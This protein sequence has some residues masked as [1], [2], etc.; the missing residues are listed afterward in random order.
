MAEHI[1][2]SSPKI[3]ELMGKSTNRSENLKTNPQI[4]L[5]LLSQIRKLHW[6]KRKTS[7]TKSLV[8]K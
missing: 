1:Y 4:I 5:S 8:L 3:F 2:Q 6:K 7:A